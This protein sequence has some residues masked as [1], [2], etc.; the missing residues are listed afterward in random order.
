MTQQY[1]FSRAQKISRLKS[2]RL[3][4]R[5]QFHSGEYVYTNGNGRYAMK[6][7]RLLAATMSSSFSGGRENLSRKQ[8]QNFYPPRITLITEDGSI[9][10]T[11]P[12]VGTM[13]QNKGLL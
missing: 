12:Y 10:A 9:I 6:F 7:Q 11:S 1:E 5:K 3:Q 4:R 2:A 8:Q 13:P